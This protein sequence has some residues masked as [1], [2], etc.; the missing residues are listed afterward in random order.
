MK[1][2]EYMKQSTV[3]LTDGDFLVANTAAVGYLP[4]Y[5]DTVGL[6]SGQYIF[7]IKAGAGAGEFTIIPMVTAADQKTYVEDTKNPIITVKP[8]QVQYVTNR[9]DP[10]FRDVYRSPN[11]HTEEVPAGEEARHALAAFIAFADA[12]YSLGVQHFQI[13][14]ADYLDI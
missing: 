12:E 1:L 4:T 5:K 11:A 3:T 14:G 10:K 7:K 13:E 8:T 2:A 6:H 9:N